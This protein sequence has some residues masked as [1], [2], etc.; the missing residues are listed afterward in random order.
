MQTRNNH[1]PRL[2]ADVSAED[3]IAD[4]LL[5]KEVG[6]SWLCRSAIDVVGLKKDYRHLEKVLL[7]S[8]IG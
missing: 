4:C 7:L 3:R 8:L 2:A 1:A 5:D 6:L